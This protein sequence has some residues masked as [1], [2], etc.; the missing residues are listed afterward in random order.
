MKICM[1]C[2]K[3]V[4]DNEKRCP[5]CGYMHDSL[6]EKA[7]Y[8]EPGTIIEAKYV[9]GKA[10]SYDGNIIRYIGLDAELQRKIIVSE[11]LP[12]RFSTRNAEETEVTIYSGN[13]YDKFAEGLEQFLN[14]ASK[15]QQL[16]ELNSL[17]QIYDCII[18][19]DTGYVIEEYIE[20]TSL[21]QILDSGK[22]YAADE[23]KNIISQI[24]DSIAKLHREGIMHGDICLENIMLTNDGMF[25]LLNPVYIRN[26]AADDSSDVRI[27]L[28]RGYTSEERYRRDGEIGTWT[29]VYSL[30]A[31]M[32]KMITGEEPEEAVERTLNDKLQPPSKKGVKIAGSVENALMNALNVYKRDRTLTAEEFYIE[33]N[34]KK[35]NKRKVKT[36]KKKKRIIPISVKIAAVIVICLTIAVGIFF[37]KNKEDRS[38][39]NQSIAGKKYTLEEKIRNGNFTLEDFKRE[40]ND[41]Y[42]FP[43]DAYEIEFRYQKDE[44][45]GLIK[46]YEDKTDGVLADGVLISNVDTQLKKDN[47]KYCKI[48]VASTKYVTFSDK[49]I[50]NCSKNNW[51]GSKKISKNIS[52]PD[53]YEKS[54]IPAEISLQK[55]D[56]K[57]PYGTIGKIEYFNGKEIEQIDIDS[58]RAEDNG[59]DK[60]AKKLDKLNGLE[61]KNADMKIIYHTGAY[62]SMSAEKCREYNGFTGKNIEDVKF[63]YSRY[64]KDHKSG[65]P[66]KEQ[67]LEKSRY[68][69]C[70]VSLRYSKG[71]I[72]DV[73]SE[74]L[75]FG[76]GYDGIK[77]DSKNG[78][79]V[80]FNT[81]NEYLKIDSS[82]TVGKLKTLV[83]KYNAQI[84]NESQ[85]KDNYI[86]TAI[87]IDGKSDIKEFKENSVLKLS[88]RPPKTPAPTVLKE[89][90]KN[91]NVGSEQ[92][93][94][95]EGTSEEESPEKGNEESSST[96]DNTNSENDKDKTTN[97]VI[98]E[99]TE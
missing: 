57:A 54:Y 65:N 47:K 44:K 37:W 93:Q 34:S 74:S 36:E 81:V 92:P 4:S 75:C 60:I 80:L 35:T 59:Y 1:G 64:K 70:Y 25:K 46:V 38:S 76:K 43:E 16:G 27:V 45:D 22:V 5:V 68:N 11:Y 63:V 21:Q 28:K 67:T 96:S 10:L 39:T 8:L 23:A 49:W 85:Y 97:D 79:G 98:F 31:V 2:M 24:A 95:T 72:V 78:D 17:S 88:V 41:E 84:K 32:Y 66:E 58:L 26:N 94:K 19:N 86:V 3:P 73:L 53:A 9:V 91:N 48:I 52:Y 50:D 61:L 20:G 6:K 30:A 18:E 13:A 12:E 83:K 29:D 55:G 62:Y 90:D 42:K 7:Y 56:S 15:I 87:E 71:T 51:A 69:A 89:N 14:N 77:D 40:W 82:L 99:I 33:L